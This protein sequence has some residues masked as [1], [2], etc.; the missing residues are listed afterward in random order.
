MMY[1]TMAHPPRPGS[2]LELLFTMIQMRREAAQLMATRAIVQAVRDESE[3]GDATQRAYEDY[4]KTLMPY[5][6]QDEKEAA[7]RVK[8]AMARE[9]A[10]GPMKISP[11]VASTAVRSRLKRLV[12]GLKEAERP[13]LVWKRK[14]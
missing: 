11:I 6:A 8:A 12:R 5:T 7:E 10:M 2:L 1:D 9:F 3:S 14:T 4:R 13:E